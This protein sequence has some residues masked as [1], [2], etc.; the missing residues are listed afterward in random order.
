MG[1]FWLS[2]EYGPYIYH[3]SATG[4]LLQAISPPDAILPKD[5]SGNLNFTS[6]EDPLIG[7]T[8]RGPNQGFEGLTLDTKTN[9]LYAMLQTATLQDGGAD[10]GT[11]RYTRLVAYDVNREPA[12]LVGEW[13]VPS[14]Q[15]KKGNTRGQSE[16]HFIGHDIFLVLSRDGDG[17]GSDETESS[18]KQ[19]D[20]FSIADATDIP[21]Y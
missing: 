4:Q 12:K 15:S 17:K 8:G 5:A 21:R 6:S 19:A 3:Y 18:Y 1:T 20:L 2:D 10:K 13:V 7:V 9:T 11:S 16:I 14:P